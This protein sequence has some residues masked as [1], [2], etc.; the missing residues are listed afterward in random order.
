MAAPAQRYQ[1]IVDRS[2]PDAL[3]VAICLH[4]A[5]SRHRTHCLARKGPIQARSADPASFWGRCV[6]TRGA[7]FIVDSRP[8]RCAYFCDASRIARVSRGVLWIISTVL[9]F[10]DSRLTR[11]GIGA[12][13]F[14]I[15]VGGGVAVV[16]GADEEATGAGNDSATCTDFSMG[17]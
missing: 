10:S 8:W 14:D 9:S 16:A 6:D 17:T 13:D 4:Q 5:I 2:T 1:P 3:S 7:C 12:G 15:G 11:G